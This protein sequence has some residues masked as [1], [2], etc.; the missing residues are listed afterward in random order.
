MQ[1]MRFTIEEINNGS[2]RDGLLPGVSLGYQIY[3]TCTEPASILATIDLLVQQSNYYNVK[4]LN[5]TLESR[6]IAII[7]PDSSSYAFTSA[8]TLGYYLMPQISYEASNQM[9]SNKLLYPAFFRTIPSDNNQVRAIVQ[10]LRRFNWTW[11]ALLG[12]DNDYG[13]DGLQSLSTVAS[14]NN[15]CIAYQGIIPKYTDSTREQ[16]ITMIKKI[17]QTHV[18][19]IVVFSSKRIATGF[20]QLVVEQNVTGKVWIGSEDWSVSTMVSGLPGIQTIGSVLG[21]GVKTAKMLGFQEFGVLAMEAAAY[22]TGNSSNDTGEVAGHGL[23]CLQGCDHIQTLTTRDIPL[24]LYDIQSSYNVYKAV[25]ALAHALRSS[26]GCNSGKCAKE[27]VQPFNVSLHTNYACGMGGTSMYFDQNGDPPTGYDIMAWDWA[28]GQLS[29]RVVGTFSPDPADLKINASL[30][31]WNSDSKGTVPQSLCSPDCPKG[32]RRLQTGSHVCCF[33]CQICPVD[34]FLNKTGLTF[35]QPCLIHEWSLSGSERCTNRTVVYLPWADWVSVVLLLAS[36][37][38][39]FLTLVTAALFLVNLSTPVVKS[40]GGRTCLVML[41]SLA[42]AT[43]STLCH[44]GVPTLLACILKQSLF[45]LSFTVCLSCMAVRSLQIVCIFK[46]SA[47]L[48]RAYEVWAR[49]NGPSIVIIVS[50]ATEL[51]I[52]LMH[53][54]EEQPSPTE[55]YN[56]YPHAILLECSGAQAIGSMLELGYITMLSFL[57]F[58]FSYLGKDLPANYNEA[59]CVTF[60]LLVYLI[61]WLAFSTVYIVSRGKYSIIVNVIAVL[62]SVLGILGGYFLPKVYIIVLKPQLNTAAHFQNCIQMYTTKKSEN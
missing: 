30:I 31:N 51:F 16:M 49:N 2:S 21:I 10:L 17:M 42:V 53:V 18:N 36:A 43:C 24:E 54:L 61:S 28:G 38:T 47:K 13:Q 23:R 25:Y 26:L 45:T 52:S 7:G 34:T 12:S 35:C 57:C 29:L 58:A 27:D 48:P 15:I 60:S 22:A 6:A 5:G 50:A 3:D 56:I 40:A 46:M 62:A 33:D 44:F 11:I 55:V 9:L 1:A 19:T 32:S 39:L 4:K 8:T 14:D 41:A 59:K 37:L 20:F